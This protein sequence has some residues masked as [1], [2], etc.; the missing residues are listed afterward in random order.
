[1]DKVIKEEFDLPLHFTGDYLKHDTDGWGD[2]TIFV[3]DPSSPLDLID[4]WNI[5]QFEDQVLAVDIAWLREAKEFITEVVKLNHRPLPGNPHGVMITTTVQFARSISEDRAKSATAGAGLNSLAHEWSFKLWY[6]AIWSPYRND[7]VARPQRT[8]VWAATS[9]LELAL[10]D[11]DGVDLRCRFRSL[12][13][14]FAPTYSDGTARWVNVLD[15]KNYGMN[16][17]L[18]LTLPLTFFDNGRSSLRI[19]EATIISREGFVLPQHFK[20]QAEYFR[21]L[22]GQEAI[23]DWLKS[24]G[25]EAEV[26]DPG[27]I[28]NQILDS[29]KGFWGVGL[30]ADRD[31][32]MLL[33]EMSKS[34]RKYAD[35]KLLEEFPDRSIDVKRW[36]DLAKKRA[37]GMFGHRVSL[38]AF[39]KANVLR[40]GLVLQCTNCRKRNWF[41]IENLRQQLTCE[42]CLKIYEFPQG[43]LHFERTPWQ[44]RVIGP[45]SVPNF[46]E[47]AYATVLALST[48]AKGL[49]GDRANITYS[50]GLHFKIADATP[51]EVDFTFWYQRRRILGLQEEPLL[52]FGE[53]KSF[54]TQSFKPE[55]VE[56]MRKLADKF[57][58][59]FLIFALL[60]DA[61]SDA[62]KAE[63]GQFAVW[64]RE[65]LGNGKP[66]APVIVLTGIELFSAWNVRHTWKGLG[67]E[68]AKF[69][70]RT[71]VSLDDLWSLA[72]ITQQLYLGLLT[73]PQFP[74]T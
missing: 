68:W 24:Q 14:D 52:A 45:Y 3:L 37:S 69:A 72:E 8:R 39:I 11:E 10:E 4:L 28:A 25:V 1:M 29:T 48:I 46:A 2:P 70:E 41:G 33:D 40:L 31:T 15:F 51:F 18:A 49:S 20:D 38:D 64:G 61:L 67:G 5:R 27:Q 34:V 16:D 44:Y 23:I 59:A 71:R 66:R 47:G 7:L 60:K 12:S 65:R 9:D 58:G 53:A 74:F 21:L 35:G 30:L 13:P 62:E 43:S 17:T 26:S 22:T 56:R 42:R 36:K 6:D 54:A 32:I 73:C 19:G 57:P 50:T 55:D 63:I